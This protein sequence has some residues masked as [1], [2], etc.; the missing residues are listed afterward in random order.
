MSVL[1]EAGSQRTDV[2]QVVRMNDDLVRDIMLMF[3]YMYIQQIQLQ[4]FCQ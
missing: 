1:P 4:V 3:I 2:N